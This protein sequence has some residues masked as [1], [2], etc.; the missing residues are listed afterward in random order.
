M[1]LVVVIV[2]VVTP[3]SVDAVDA[4]NHLHFDGCQV[5]NQSMAFVIVVV[6]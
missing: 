5:F 1:A 4:E 2:V 6:V 3:L